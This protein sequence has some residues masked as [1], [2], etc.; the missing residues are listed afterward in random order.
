MNKGYLGQPSIIE[1][2]VSQANEIRS[3]NSQIDE[4]KLRGAL[5]SFFEGK[6]LISEC[7]TIFVDIIGSESPIIF[8]KDIMSIEI[9]KNTNCQIVD[10]DVE[11]P[12]ANA[13]SSRRKAR[14]WTVDED[15]RLLA[16]ILYYG[17]D[18]WSL[19]SDV[20]GMNR[21]RAQCSQRWLRGLDP[22]I[23]KKRW[24]SEEDRNLIDLVK[25]HG[26]TAWAKIASSMGNRSDVQ[27]R[28]H[29]QQLKKTQQKNIIRTDLVSYS[30]N[31]EPINILRTNFIA[32]IARVPYRSERPLP[33][34]SI[35]S[36]INSQN[37]FDE[38]MERGRTTSL[39]VFLQHFG[40]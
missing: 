12:P 5:L 26:E 22:R 28:Y 7:S 6:L 17:T 30:Q 34:L 33:P 11:S 13:S 16:G 14:P 29:F 24:S 32:P 3:D 4:D 40:Q 38:D 1:F 21:S 27:C 15:K 9:E 37:S 18:N 25:E 19:V 10:N 8:L 23:C 39:D 2:I 36:K 20:V 31:N 35:I